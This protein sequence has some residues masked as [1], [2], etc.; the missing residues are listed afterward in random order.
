MTPED[1]QHL[2][3]MRDAIKAHE[4]VLI[5]HDEAMAAA[6]AA[7]RAAIDLFQRVTGNGRH[8]Q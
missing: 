1:R 3:R 8:G 2:R 4:D 7:T 6:L 5:A